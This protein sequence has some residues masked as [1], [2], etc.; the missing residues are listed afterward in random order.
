MGGGMDLRE[1]WMNVGMV[2]WMD[3]QKDGWMNEQM[4]GQ[5]GQ[6]DGQ[7]FG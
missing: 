7:K 2:R 1:G 5:D 4:N 6:M 3:E